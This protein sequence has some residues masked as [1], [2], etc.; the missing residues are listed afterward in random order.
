MKPTLGPPL[1][2]LYRVTPAA[3]HEVPMSGSG[4]RLG[5]RLVFAIDAND[6]A[7]RSEAE[8]LKALH[9]VVKRLRDVRDV[10]ERPTAEALEVYRLKERE[11]L[12]IT[13]IARRFASR[14]R[15]CNDNES[16]ERRAKR[17]VQQVRR[18]LA[19]AKARELASLTARQRAILEAAQ[20][21]RSRT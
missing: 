15:N 3:L 4:V 8:L 1:V 2:R 6:L 11:G 21:S 19:R 5:E 13:E 9:R 17:N 14:W 20:Q 16:R 12:T 18:Y 10:R 7:E